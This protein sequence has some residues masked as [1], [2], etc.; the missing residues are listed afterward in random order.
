MWENGVLRHAGRV[1]LTRTALEEFGKSLRSTDEVVMEATGN[2]TAV[3]RVLTPFVAR[4]V[5]AHPL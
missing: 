3:A 4:V 2:S 5:I 1:G